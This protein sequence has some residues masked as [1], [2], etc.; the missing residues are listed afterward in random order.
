MSSRTLPAGSRKYAACAFQNGNGTTGEPSWRSTSTR[1]SSHA[2][3]SSSRSGATVK[4]TWWMRGGGPGTARKARRVAPARTA[5]AP[6]SAASSGSP[7]RL[8]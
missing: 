6:S 2:M 3:P 8:A 1:R 5:K 7:S 4:A